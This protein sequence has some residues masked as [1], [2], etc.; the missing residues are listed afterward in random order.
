KTSTW[1]DRFGT[2][3]RVTWPVGTGYRGS[4]NRFISTTPGSIAYAGY[5]EAVT[6]RLQIGALQN[7]DDK[8][9]RCDKHTVAAAGEQALA[10]PDQVLNGQLLD[11]PGKNAYPVCSVTRAVFYSK[12]NDDVRERLR[13]FLHWATHDGQALAE[14]AN[15][16]P[17]PASYNNHFRKIVD[18]IE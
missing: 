4:V 16:V 18:S 7:R 13:R 3:L 6:L 14:H 8:C 1:A 5:S 2:G 17:L 11:M 15:C 10:S 12:Q 9:V